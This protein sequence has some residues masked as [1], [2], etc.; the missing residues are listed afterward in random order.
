MI[1]THK[2]EGI[3]K[4]IIMNDATNITE[5]HEEGNVIVF[6]KFIPMELIDALDAVQV[7]HS[8]QVSSKIKKAKTPDMTLPYFIQDPKKLKRALDACHEIKKKILTLVTDNFE[9]QFAEDLWA[10]SGETWRFTETT[11]ENMHYDVF[12]FP[13]EMFVRLFT[14]LSKRNRV[15]RT[16]YNLDQFAE[17]YGTLGATDAKDY[18]RAA[19]F[20]GIYGPSANGKEN[21]DKGYKFPYIEMTFEPGDLW[22][23]H[24]QLVS[25]QIMSGD[26]MM[27]M[28]LR[29]FENQMKNPN[30][31]VTKMWESFQ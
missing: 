7:I 3:R 5:N 4:E 24:S 14:N 26:K 27:A 15:W 21:E 11:F 12:Y 30:R 19:S 1:I 16:S 31:T 18:L 22:F 2:D 29:V 20:D 28:S 23:G 6:E 25:H 13:D 17:K 10:K 9:Y 8:S